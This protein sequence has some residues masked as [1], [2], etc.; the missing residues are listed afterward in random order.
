MPNLI[1]CKLTQVEACLVYQSLPK[2]KLG[3]CNLTSKYISYIL[4][5]VLSCKSVARILTDQKL[6]TVH[7]S[8]CFKTSKHI[9]GHLLYAFQPPQT[10]RICFCCILT[11]KWINYTYLLCLYFLFVFVF[12]SLSKFL[13]PGLNIFF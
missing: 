4:L 3:C 1:R 12:S 10:L 7:L 13:F 6:T 2:W 5:S 9:C 11:W 8:W